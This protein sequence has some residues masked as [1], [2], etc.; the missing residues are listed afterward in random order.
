[1]GGELV[2]WN[3]LNGYDLKQI[4]KT[5]T[6]MVPEIEEKRFLEKNPRPLPEKPKNP[7]QTKDHTGRTIGELFHSAD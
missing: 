5:V 3:G 7:S 6:P 2:I 1:M 4:A